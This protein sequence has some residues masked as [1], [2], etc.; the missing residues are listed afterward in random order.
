MLCSH[1]LESWAGPCRGVGV[2][3]ARARLVEKKRRG[4]P[5]QP[6]RSTREKPTGSA[7]AVARPRVAMGERC[8]NWGTEEKERGKRE[9]G[10]RRFGAAREGVSKVIW[11][12]E[13][14]RSAA[15]RNKCWADPGRGGRCARGAVLRVG[16]TSW[17]FGSL[18]TVCPYR[19]TMSD[20]TLTP[21]FQGGAPRGI[22]VPSCGSGITNDGTAGTP[23]P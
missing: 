10:Q 21:G 11:A 12:G 15:G 19:R 2:G 22:R 8:R 14:K 7:N 5:G 9:R 17:R 6:A 3:G 16:S 1:S 13:S 20:L 18:K 23:G 4:G